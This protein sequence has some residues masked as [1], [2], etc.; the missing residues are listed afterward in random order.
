VVF[1]RPKTVVVGTDE[2]G[3]SI[4]NS[5]LAQAAIDNGFTVELCAPRSPEQTGSVENLVGFV[6]RSFFRARRFADGEADLERNLLEMVNEE[7]PSRATGER[8]PG[9]DWRRRSGG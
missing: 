9:S 1:D 7:R 3:R 5:T 4:W 6:K 2:H 8:C